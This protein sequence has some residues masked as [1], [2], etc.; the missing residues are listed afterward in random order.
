MVLKKKKLE[1]F[2]LKKMMK[3]KI[4]KKNL[5]NYIYKYSNLLK[6]NNKM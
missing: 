1:K 4:N 6:F 2:K 5:K 3:S